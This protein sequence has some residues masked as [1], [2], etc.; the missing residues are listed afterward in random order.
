MLL[1]TAGL[2]SYLDAADAR[3]GDAVAL[4]GRAPQRLTHNYILAELVALGHAR[5]VNRQ[6]IL[7]FVAEL[8]DDPDIDVR[9]ITEADH[10][11]AV[12][13]LQARP[14]KAYSLRDAVS[15]VL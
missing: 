14:D 5:R 10:R 7:G 1:D 3:H 13:L 9:W 8:A 15:F 2:L 6:L 12:A 11:A 4:M